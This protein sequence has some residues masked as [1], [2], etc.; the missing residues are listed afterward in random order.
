M[1]TRCHMFVSIS[2]VNTSRVRTRDS[3]TVK[4]MGN[5]VYSYLGVVGG[6]LSSHGGI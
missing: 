6:S 1:D 3:G 4:I 2:K 5:L